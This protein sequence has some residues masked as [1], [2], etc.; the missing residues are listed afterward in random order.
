MR[1]NWLSN[2]IFKPCD[3]IVDH[4]CFAWSKL[5]D[6][7][8]RIMSIGL[9]EVRQRSQR[10][11][12]LSEFITGADVAAEC[13]GDITYMWYVTDGVVFKPKNRMF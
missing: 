11:L 3:D 5:I 8:W 2:W 4:S 7:P 10:R 12:A 6:Q 9:H 13:I 1:N